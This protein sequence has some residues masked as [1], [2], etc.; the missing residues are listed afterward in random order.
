MSGYVVLVIERDDG[1]IYLEQMSL[2][3]EVAD[4]VV[5][6][7]PFID[8]RDAITGV[9]DTIHDLTTWTTEWDNPDEDTVVVLGALNA[10]PGRRPTLVAV[11]KYTLTLDAVTAGKTLVV[12]GLT[13]T[14][15]ATTTTVANREFSIAGGTDTLDADELRHLRRT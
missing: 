3:R 13:Y 8:Q 4:A 14:A 10:E 1:N 6:Y 12:N 9:Y 15:H 5:L 2:E 7:T 11:D